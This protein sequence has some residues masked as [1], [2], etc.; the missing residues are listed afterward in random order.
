MSDVTAL[1]MQCKALLDAL[2]QDEESQAFFGPMRDM[3]SSALARNDHVYLQ[4]LLK[5]LVAISRDFPDRLTTEALQEFGETVP[6]IRSEVADIIKKGKI[7]DANQFRLV[8]EY[9]DSVHQNQ[10]MAP[11][12]EAL[13]RMLLDFEQKEAKKRGKHGS[14]DD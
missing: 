6:D 13:G 1:Y 8:N 14:K 2:I 12:I 11:V 9:I 5:E 3:A 7:T 10:E 4:R